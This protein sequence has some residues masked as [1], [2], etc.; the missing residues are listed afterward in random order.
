M[1]LFFPCIFVNHVLAMP[2][3]ARV[4][5]GARVTGGCELSCSF[6]LEEQPVLST[7]ELLL[8][9]QSLQFYNFLSET[10]YSRIVYTARLLLC[11]TWPSISLLR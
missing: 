1:G 4:P 3:E 11:C 10:C 2:L 6:L 9:P 8:Q 7:A 5:D